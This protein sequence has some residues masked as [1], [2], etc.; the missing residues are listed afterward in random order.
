MR[1]AVTKL[2]PSAI[3]P[4]YAHASDACFDIYAQRVERYEFDASA[5]KA[6]IGT[7]LSFAIPDGWA[8]L[9]FSRSGMGF[10]ENLRLANC[11]GV[12]DSGYRGELMVKLTKDDIGEIKVEPG[13]R[14]AQGMLVPVERIQFMEVESLPGSDRGDNGFGSS[15]Q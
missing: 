5:A 11:V 8:M 7:G 4:T 10:K 2:T 15:G 13:Q 14:V 9:V 3:L 6:V 1:L 12:I